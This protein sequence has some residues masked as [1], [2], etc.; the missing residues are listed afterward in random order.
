MSLISPTNSKLSFATKPQV[1]ANNVDTVALKVRVRNAANQPVKDRR[2]RII[3]NEPN[4]IISQPQL[5]DIN[6]VAI[7]YAKTAIAGPVTFTATVLPDPSNEREGAVDIENTVTANF[8]SRDIEPAPQLQNTQRN[9]H[10]T[11]SVSR[12]Q[13]NDID[14]IRV[15]IEADDANLMPIKIFAYQMMPVKPGEFERVGAFDHVCSA[16]DLEEYPEDVPVPN[17]RPEWFR[18]EYVDVLLRSRE[19]VREFIKSVV[20]DVHILKNT[21]DITEELLPAGDMWIGTPPEEES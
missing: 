13:T 7:G 5:T 11:W 8:Y 21:L 1:F 6:G 4:T 14:G 3:S 9:I 10:L 18:I 20:E 16:V 17:S 15:R 12:Y 19:E 2:V